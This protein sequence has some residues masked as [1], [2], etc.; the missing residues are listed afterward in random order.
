MHYIWEEGGELLLLT[1]YTY[2]HFRF[3]KKRKKKN[4]KAILLQGLAFKPAGH[5]LPGAEETYVV[6]L[7]ITPDSA[8]QTHFKVTLMMDVFKF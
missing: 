4:P 2:V 5:A 6:V 3:F 7:G 1:P 8:S